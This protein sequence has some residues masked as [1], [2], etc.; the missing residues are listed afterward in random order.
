MVSR[1]PNVLIAMA[2]TSS[3]PSMEQLELAQQ[4]SNSVQAHLFALCPQLL[5]EKPIAI[6]WVQK[7]YLLDSS[8]FWVQAP[9]F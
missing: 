8:A 1:H 4:F 2:I 3:V 7:R 5:I 6:G 9:A